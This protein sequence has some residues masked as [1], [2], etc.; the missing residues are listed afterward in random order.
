VRPLLA[1][2]A[3]L[4]CACPPPPPVARPYPPPS[5]EA[6]MAHLDA[7]ARKITSLRTDA[8]VDHAEGGDRVKLTAH[9]LLAEQGRLRVE[10]DAP[11]GGGSVGTLVS[12]GK[13]IQLLDPRA[14]KFYVG[15]ASAC[16][17]ARLLHIELQP[18]DAIAVLTGGAPLAG[19]LGK[20]SWDGGDGGREVLELALPDGGREVLRLDARDR[21]W[22]L[23][24]AERYDA[25]GRLLWRVR[26]GEFRLVDGVRLP[27]RTQI[28]QPDRNID[29]RLRF[30]DPELNA[31]VEPAQLRLTPTLPPQ[32]IDC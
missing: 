6:L 1:A 26:H 4:L 19:T 7:R 20:L 3:L 25:A 11:I 14:E 24:E 15:P 27:G 10:L 30:R 32:P 16:L 18:E 13:T 31:P 22:D 5:A 2:A 8:K 9:L 12:D 29:T 21:T 17:L 28:E 23:R